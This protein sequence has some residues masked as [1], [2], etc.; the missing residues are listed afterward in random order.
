MSK[1]ALQFTDMIA[2]K[3]KK[4]PQPMS[5]IDAENSAGIKEKVTIQQFMQRSKIKYI[6]DYNESREGIM[7]AIKRGNG[8]ANL[9]NDTTVLDRK[10]IE[11]REMLQKN[12]VDI[13]MF[14][15]ARIKQELKLG[16]SPQFMKE[17]FQNTGAYDIACELGKILQTITT[18]AYGSIEGLDR[19]IVRASE[20]NGLTPE[21]LQ[22]AIQLGMYEALDSDA[23]ESKIDYIRSRIQ[24]FNA[25]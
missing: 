10:A 4:D 24:Q 22:T 14:P 13:K 5:I 18:M 11:I 15:M 2:R 19:A 23:S 20:A 8:Y 16:I 9:L 25:I 6:D 17:M 3:N 12:G 21:E 7:A 1:Y